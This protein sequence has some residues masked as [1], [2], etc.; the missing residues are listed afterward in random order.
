MVTVIVPTALL[1]RRSYE[2]RAIGVA[3][4][5]TRSI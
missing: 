4:E 2:R 5:N 3:A 1:A